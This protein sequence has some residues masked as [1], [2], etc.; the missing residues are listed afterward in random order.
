M[1]SYTYDQVKRA[2]IALA[3]HMLP[4][5]EKLPPGSHARPVVG[6]MA[7]HSADYLVWMLAMAR[8]KVTLMLL[9]TRNSQAALENLLNKTECALV[10]ATPPYAHIAGLAAANAFHD[11]KMTRIDALDL[12][13]LANDPAA[14]HGASSLPVPTFAPDEI[15]D[16]ALIIHSSGSTD[17]PKPIRLSNRYTLHLAN[18]KRVHFESFNVKLT[19]D[20]VFMSNMPLFHVVGVFTTLS[21]A[22][23][24]ASITFHDQFPPSIDTLLKTIEKQ[25][26]TLIMTAPLIVEHISLRLLDDDAP[27]AWK[28]PEYYKNIRMLQYGGAPLKEEV[29]SHLVDMLNINLCP[30]YGTTEIAFFMGSSLSDRRN[31][32]A[33]K[34]LDSIQLYAKW[35]AEEMTTPDSQPL[36]HLTVRSDCPTLA[37]AIAFRDDGVYETN[38]L[39]YKSSE[40]PGYWKYF[41][42]RDD[43]IAFA[44]GEK[45]NPLPMEATLRTHHIISEAIVGGSGRPASFALIELDYSVANKLSPAEIKHQVQEAIND[46]NKDAPN[47]AKILKQLVYILPP[48]KQMPKTDKGTAIR[49]RV[50]AEYKDVIDRIYDAFLGEGGADRSDETRL[51][52]KAMT[53]AQL[54]TCLVHAAAD[55]MEVPESLINENLSASLFDLGLNSLLATQLRHKM[56]AWFD[57]VPHNFVYQHPSVDSLAKALLAGTDAAINDADGFERT[58]ELTEQYLARADRDF[59][60]VNTTYSHGHA[61]VYMVSGVTG[62]IGSFALQDLL[63]R[64]KTTTVYCLIRAKTPE[65]AKER[66]VRTFHERQLDVGLLQACLAANTVIPLVMN[67]DD[68]RLGLSDAQF[69]EI[70]ANVSIILHCAWLLDFNQGIDHFD[71]ATLRGMYNLLKFAYRGPDKPAMHVHTLS[72]VSATANWDANLTTADGKYPL[73]PEEPLPENPRDSTMP[74]GY[75]QSKYIVERLFQFLAQKKQMPVFVERVGQIT[76]DTVHGVWN[77]D[78]QYP[79][80]I[81]GG[82]GIMHKMPDL[83]L[84]ID[85]LPV[86][87]AARSIN[88]VMLAQWHQAIIRPPTPPN[89][90]EKHF[91]GPFHIVNPHMTTWRA[92]LATL[93]DCGLEFDTVPMPEWIDALAHD[94]TNPAYRLMSFYE[95][96]LSSTG[97]LNMPVWDTTRTLLTARDLQSAPA[98]NDKALFAKY[99]EQWRRVSAKIF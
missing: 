47:F 80:M 52:G 60:T 61:A 1:A 98:V 56:L 93:R 92:I 59:D 24:G 99:I 64:N 38:D 75:A 71:R 15:E 69:S 94:E 34:V 16:I 32:H 18:F 68:E 57:R 20:D 11:C 37:T 96:S 22:Q 36:F 6:F 89:S 9:S 19:S 41:G 95:A 2:S 55:V 54:T 14:E 83:D 40:F 42:R 39:F 33:L 73:I 29:A 74:M 26:V 63:L 12:P 35:E 79:L 50:I 49:K 86:D 77:Y 46:A 10:L 91:A 23:F 53:E 70:K 85:W 30:A 28:K 88:D 67:L 65:D 45:T 84:I 76:G 90:G 25:R 21:V 81:V 13:A 78:E 51:D 31:C 44:N 8:C 97:D 43:T 72:S 58:K 17:F 27:D 62:S 7:D 82:A 66:L 3:R 4:Q 87:Y 48:D 5:I